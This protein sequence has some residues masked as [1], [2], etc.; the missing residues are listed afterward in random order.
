[1]LWNPF[2]FKSKSPELQKLEDVLT[3]L[4]EKYVDSVNTEQIFDETIV[5]MLHKLDPHSNYIPAEEMK[6]LAESIDGNFGGVGVRFFKLR[7]TIC[8]SDVIPGSPSESV[9]LRA[10]DQIVSI[11]KNNAAG[12][13][14]TNAEIMKSLK[15]RQAHM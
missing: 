3:L 8:V 7:D 6:A 10:G 5:E 12:V 14:I 1:L 13:G 4:N 2:D 11:E 15:E 9:G